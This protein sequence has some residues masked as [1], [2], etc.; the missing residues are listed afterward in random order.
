MREREKETEREGGMDGW[1]KGR[2]EIDCVC[3]SGRNRI[4]HAPHLEYCGG[5]HRDGAL[6]HPMRAGGGDRIHPEKL[7][8]A[9]DTERSNKHTCGRGST[10]VARCGAGAACSTMKHQSLTP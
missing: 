10:S 6:P 4:A 1:R 3:V 5:V 7:A 9:A 2:R 8:R